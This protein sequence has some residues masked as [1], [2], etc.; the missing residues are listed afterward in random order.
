M[1]KASVNLG[2]NAFL[3]EPDTLVRILTPV[4]E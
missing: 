2:H 4:F 1:A 3:A